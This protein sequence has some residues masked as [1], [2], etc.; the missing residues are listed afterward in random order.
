MHTLY[1]VLNKHKMPSISHCRPMF[2]FSNIEKNDS[3]MSGHN[4]VMSN[5]VFMMCTKVFLVC[6]ISSQISTK[7]NVRNLTLL[8][9]LLLVNSV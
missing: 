8:L 2:G 4:S 6:L 5:Q 3:K 7:S 9:L 1:S